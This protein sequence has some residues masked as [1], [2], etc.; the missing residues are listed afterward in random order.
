MTER[1]IEAIR[2]TFRMIEP[3]ANAA[4]VAFY[5]RMFELDPTMRPL[6]HVTVEE[7][8]KKLAQV[9]A[10]V[11]KSLDRMEEILPAVRELGARHTQYCVTEQ[12]HATGGAAL[13]WTPE[14]GLGEAFTAEVKESWS[15]AYCT[16]IGAM[17]ESAVPV[18]A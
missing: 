10:I 6:F 9:I 14:Q 3:T 7:Q 15:L 1:Q 8:G 2:S 4:M 16:L 18:G 13:L 12:H 11:V 5:E 17:M